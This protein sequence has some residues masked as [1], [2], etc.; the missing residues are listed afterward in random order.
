MQVTVLP[1]DLHGHNGLEQEDL[2]AYARGARP[3]L[4]MGGSDRAT[5][6]RRRVGPQRCW[7][8]MAARPA[9]LLPTLR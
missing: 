1:R 4:T 2:P 6:H 5:Q 8:A 3:T 9:S 7:T